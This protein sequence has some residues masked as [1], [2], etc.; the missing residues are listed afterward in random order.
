MRVCV[1]AVV[2]TQQ[3]T[4]RA[5]SCV[6]EGDQVEGASKVQSH[7]KL[8]EEAEHERPQAETEAEEPQGSPQAYQN[9]KHSTTQVGPRWNRRFKFQSP[10]S[11][12][13]RRH[14]TQANLNRKRRA[15]YVH[16]AD[17]RKVKKLVPYFKRKSLKQRY[18]SIGKALTHYS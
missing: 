7:Q 11:R 3:K 15:R 14:K 6:Q 5:E 9:R 1:H 18:W 13:L 8:L 10:G 17:M 16:V 12:H 4:S 2:L